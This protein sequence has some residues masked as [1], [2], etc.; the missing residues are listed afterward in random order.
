MNNKII[1]L[2]SV[3]CGIDKNGF[4][5]PMLNNGKYDLEMETHILDID[6]KEWFKSLDKKDEE[7]INQYVKNKTNFWGV[8]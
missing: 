5:F 2:N 6:N 7:I 4:V 8:K 3:G 1:A